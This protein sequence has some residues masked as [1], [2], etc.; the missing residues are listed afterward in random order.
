MSSVQEDFA[1]EFG[2]GHVL[3]EHH[4][5]EDD[6]EPGVDGG[7]VAQ[8]GLRLSHAG[9]DLA[10]DVDNVAE[11][12]NVL[13]GVDVRFGNA[14]GEE[15]VAFLGG[16]KD[17]DSG[18]ALSM[19]S[20]D[21]ILHEGAFARVL[22]SKHQA[23]EATLHLAFGAKFL[24]MDGRAIHVLSF[25]TTKIVWG[26][27]RDFFSFAQTNFFF[28]LKEKL[29]ENIQNA[30]ANETVRPMREAKLKAMQTI[31]EYTQRQEALKASGQQ[32]KADEFGLLDT[33]SEDEDY[34][35]DDETIDDME[36]ED[37]DEDDEEVE[38]EDDEADE[39]DEA[40]DD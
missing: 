27:S 31:R 5:V 37:E 8:L 34:V 7:D 10:L 16:G 17:D 20:E 19:Q 33:D 6:D 40:E 4:V 24:H 13:A 14:R 11:L 18:V 1:K 3:F 25:V 36:D 29:M 15:M 32:P 39:D 23:V 12:M 21:E 30:N 35:E 26:V 28:F 2:L 38:H 22:V 9:D